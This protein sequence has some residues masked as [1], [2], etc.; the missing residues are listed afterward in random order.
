MKKFWEFAKSAKFTKLCSCKKQKSTVLCG[1][2]LST[3]V[4]SV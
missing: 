1:G 4:S 3:V 2:F